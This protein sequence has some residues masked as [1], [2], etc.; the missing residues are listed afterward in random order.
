MTLVN[1]IRDGIAFFLVTLFVRTFV[2]TL[3]LQMRT[4]S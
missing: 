4:K 2:L 3:V 1:L